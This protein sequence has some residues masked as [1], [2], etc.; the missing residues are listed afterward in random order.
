[1][2]ICCYEDRASELL[3]VKLLVCSVRRHVRRVPI[4]LCVPNPPPDFER[5]AAAQP[6]LE[7][8]RT[9][10]AQ[11][12][13]WNAK[14]FLLL[15]LLDAGHDEAVWLD[16]DLIVAGDFRRLFADDWSVVSTEE[17]QR[18]SRKDARLR[19]TGWGFPLGRQLSHVLNS[20]LVRVRASHRDLLTEWARLM[21]TPEYQAA[22][23]MPLGAR[24]A[25][26]M[27]DQDVLTALLGS[28]AFAHVP[29]QLLRRGRDI[30]HDP[31]GGYHPFDR[32]ANV[33]RREPALVHAQ[34]G[35]PWRYARPPSPLAE[36][37]R[38]Y[39][40]LHVETSPYGHHARTYRGELGEDAPFLEVRSRFGRAAWALSR[41]NPH[42]P[43]MLHSML[44]IAD[45][46]ARHTLGQVGRAV[47]LGRRLGSG[48][49][50]A[51]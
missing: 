33:F 44:C 5:W 36:W 22:Q 10:D 51:R 27:G 49:L 3:G 45:A 18:H 26:M 24:P 37:S 28:E 15:R 1:M 47:R 29:L 4:H 7:L 32:V 13:G 48:S 50:S 21:R 12:R 46:N 34:S 30:I 38:Y 9:G 23:R 17:L 19:T 39:N 40:F 8:D 43:G 42:L 11:L 41:G 25:H 20:A 35:R 14:P 2:V 16:S 31:H 6:D